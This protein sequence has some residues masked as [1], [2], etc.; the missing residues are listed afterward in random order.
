MFSKKFKKEIKILIVLVIVAFT[1]KGS[2]VE[3]YVVP[4]GSMEKEIL[5]GD[6]LFGNKWIY[7]MRTPTW[8][9][10]PY[11]RLGFDLP[12]TR[13]PEF[14]ELRR[15]DVTIFEYPRDPF[16][17]YVKRCIG[18]PRDTIKI[19]SGNILYLKNGS[20][21]E[22]PLPENAQFIKGILKSSDPPTRPLYP[23]FDGNKD[24][25]KEFVVPFK[26]MQIDFKENY[27]NNNNVSWVHIISLLLQDGNTV[28]L[29]N[30]IFVLDDTTTIETGY[31]K[32]TMIDPEDIAQTAG[33]L[34]NKIKSLVGIKVDKIN[35]FNNYVREAMRDNL[36]KNIYNPWKIEIDQL[37][38]YG[39][40]FNRFGQRRFE[41]YF[42]NKKSLFNHD[43]I[44][45]KSLVH[46]KTAD[47]LS[48]TNDFIY[49]NLKVNGMNI[50]E[51]NIYTLKY[52]YYF[53]MGDNRDNS[54]D[55]RF[56]GFVNEKQILGTPIFS[57]FNLSEFK[58][59]LKLVN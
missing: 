3:V 7:G 9:G 17:K 12:W 56:W 58:P 50:S 5:V 19:E 46:Y 27:Q 15:G 21:R 13:L 11:T 54:S 22:M 51:L 1:V 28:E 30:E 20:Y 24:N 37:G 38:I 25:I 39:N 49:N 47:T 33:I 10:I 57:L 6:L 45:K 26:G 32:F 53:M 36:K 16:Q 18:V 4:T 14:K 8:L 59:N 42:P 55:S 23:L 44:N 2:I 41:R 29:E 31:R 34:K 52:D 48:N 35:E 40:E 43:W